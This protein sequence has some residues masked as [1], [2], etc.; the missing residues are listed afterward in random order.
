DCRIVAKYGGVT[1]DTVANL[2]LE[3]PYGSS[4]IAQVTGRLDV[5][6]GHGVVRI[7]EVHGDARLRASHGTMELGTAAGDVEAATSGALTIDRALGD[8][9][10]RSAH[11]PIRIR[12]VSG[13]TIR[14]DNGHPDA[15]VGVPPGARPWFHATPAPG[16]VRNEPPPDPAA[17]GS[18]RS[19]EL[20]L[21]AN[22]GNVIVRRI[23][24]PR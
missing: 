7:A 16:R 4:E 6:A 19:V 3:S 11:G 18:D 5:T 12:E 21:H 22:Y 20:H 2:V 23:T 13:G 14:L 8:V 9:T 24:T 17:A 1:A 15:D 10:A